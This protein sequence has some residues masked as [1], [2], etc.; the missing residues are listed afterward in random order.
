MSFTF[1]TV[2]VKDELVKRLKVELVNFGY[3]GNLT[4]KVLKA[5]PQSPAEL[6]CIGIN[7]TDDS[8]TSQSIT[9]GEGT[10]YNSTTKELDTFYGTFFDESMEIRVWH[11]NAD[12]RDKLYQVVRATL[13]AVRSD[14]VS[15]GLLNI[16]LRGG[17]DEQDS[18]MA[19]APMVL[20]WSTITMTY[21]NPLD[22][23]FVSTVDSIDSITAAT[24]LK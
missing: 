18:T 8:E 6:P 14:L 5:D 24:S 13:F 9:D 23:N 20:Y 3:T 16:A 1:N 19:Q 17:R 7:R 2:D 22:V 11:T 4:V 12:E 10:R 21:L 15:S